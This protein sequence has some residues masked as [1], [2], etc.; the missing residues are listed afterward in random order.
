MKPIP[1]PNMIIQTAPTI[2]TISH[3]QSIQ[4]R[5]STFASTT[6]LAGDRPRQAEAGKARGVGAHKDVNGRENV[7]CTTHLDSHFCTR[8]RDWGHRGETRF[9]TDKTRAVSS[10]RRC[11]C[12]G[13]CD[14]CQ[15]R[16]RSE[17]QMFHLGGSK[18]KERPR[19]QIIVNGVCHPS[20]D[21]VFVAED[22]GRPERQASA[23]ANASSWTRRQSACQSL[24]FFC[25]L[26]S[27]VR[28]DAGSRAFAAKPSSLAVHS[29]GVEA[30]SKRTADEQGNSVVW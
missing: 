5:P 2:H 18:G 9:P 8:R 10:I 22:I 13:H 27:S 25:F 3:L 20:A 26:S 21:D 29:H 28:T 15:K 24:W 1:P 16:E 19:S 7:H 23:R 11:D 12:C 30:H 17:N 4:Q 14:E 6:T